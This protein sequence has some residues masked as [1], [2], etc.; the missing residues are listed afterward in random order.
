MCTIPC[1]HTQH[2][3]KQNKPTENKCSNHSRSNHSRNRSSLACRL[4]RPC[5]PSWPH[6]SSCR[7]RE[8]HPPGLRSNNNT[9]GNRQKKTWGMYDVPYEQRMGN[10]QQSEP[11]G[12]EGWGHGQQNKGRRQHGIQQKGREKGRGGEGVILIDGNGK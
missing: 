2:T 9:A 3:I 5:R 8:P 6:L 7:S 1:H 11:R 12:R 10:T 4:R